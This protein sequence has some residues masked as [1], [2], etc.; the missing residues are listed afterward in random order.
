[1]ASTYTIGFEGSIDWTVKAAWEMAKDKFSE[2]TYKLLDEMWQFEEC[3][4]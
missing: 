4:F 3:Q 2:S 1:M